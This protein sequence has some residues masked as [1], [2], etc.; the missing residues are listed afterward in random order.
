MPSSNGCSKGSSL[1]RAASPPTRVSSACSGSA[2]S[3]S[4]LPTADCQAH[5]LVT[6]DEDFEEYRFDDVTD[7]QFEEGSVATSVVM[8]VNERPRA[9]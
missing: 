9:F 3:R 6:W 2:N 5:R 1:S 8:T 4:W 7:L